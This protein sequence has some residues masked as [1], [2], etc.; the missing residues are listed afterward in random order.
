MLSGTPQKYIFLCLLPA[1]I[2]RLPLYLKCPLPVTN[3][4]STCCAHLL[5]FNKVKTVKCFYNPRLTGE[6]PK[7]SSLQCKAIADNELHLIH[8]SDSN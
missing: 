6:N 7:Y 1:A 2:Q 8:L 4:L 5:Y 3:E